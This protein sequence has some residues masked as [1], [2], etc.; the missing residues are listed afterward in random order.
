MI[1]MA[2]VMPKLFSLPANLARRI[3]MYPFPQMEP[4]VTVDDLPQ[5]ALE[6]RCLDMQAYF[7][8]LTASAHCDWTF[9]D[10][11]DGRLTG[12]YESRMVGCAPWPDGTLLREW[13]RFTDVA[14][15]GKQEWGE[16][17]ILVE[18]DSWRWVLVGDAECGRRDVFDHPRPGHPGEPSYA[19]VPMNLRVGLKW[20]GFAGGNVVGVSRVAI[21]ERSWRCLKVITVA[22]HY[23]VAD[24][25]PSVYAEWY[26]GETGRTVLFRRFN[27]PGYRRAPEPTSFESLAGSPEV[28][29]EGIT[30]RHAY[31]CIP[32]VALA[33]GTG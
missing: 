6:I 24:R 12:V 4:P 20:P 22:Q 13:E 7:L 1:E 26:V 27:G 28:E 14:A 33:E 17:H 2:S 18:H 30:F 3:A 10:R 29:H 5:K 32:D 21:G 15:Q 19:P 16:R 8:P 9:Y 31:D 11:P 23:R 25:S